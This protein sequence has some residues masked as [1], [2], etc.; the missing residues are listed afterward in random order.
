MSSE[1]S[2][3]RESAC[4]WTRSQRRSEGATPFVRRIYTDCILHSIRRRFEQNQTDCTITVL[5]LLPTLTENILEDLPVEQLTHELQQKKAERLARASGEGK[6]E[7]SSMY[8]GDTASISSFQTGSFIHASQFQGDGSQSVGPRRTKAQLWNELKVTSITRAFTLIYSL[9]LL[10]ILTR[11]QLNLLGRLNYLSSVISLAQPPPPGRADSISLEDHDDGSAGAGFGND[12]ETN[13]R[14]LTFSWFLLHKG[15]AQIMSKVREAVEEVFGGISP[16]EGITATRLSDLVLDVRKRVEGGSE[17]ERYATRWLPYVLPPKEE[18]EAV[19]IESGVIT[20]PATSPGSDAQDP[21]KGEHQ[22]P[23]I[24]IDTSTGPLRQLLDET[25]DLID[26][27]TFTRIHTLLL[28]SMF[29]HLIDTRVI[30]QLY[31]QPR[32]HSPSSSISSAQHPRI[33]ELDSAVTVVPGEPRVKLA[34]ILAIITRQ[35]HAIGN[36][37][38]P[39]N[40]YVST[41]EAEVRELEAFA[42]VIYASNLDQSLE[43]NRPNTGDSGLRA[44][45]G[46]GVSDVGAEPVDELIESKLESAWTKVAGSSSFSSR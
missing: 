9:S 18:E 30:A 29:S 13:R 44:A 5:A 35:A 32:Q 4:R 31:P 26:S 11:I 46:V 3:K 27:P 25:A 7:A 41:A 12:F 2:M 24:H 39:P 38:N 1:R 20:P 40:E 37:N 36:G 19:L 16:S 42:A 6:S 45:G 28:G 14:Y 23:T 21:E 17:Q 10:T 8:D 43:E 22:E 15:Y 33:Q 34:N